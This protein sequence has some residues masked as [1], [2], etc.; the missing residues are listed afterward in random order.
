MKLVLATGEF[1]HC[2]SGPLIYSDYVSNYYDRVI[3]EDMDAEMH[4]P[5]DIT[6]KKI[7]D[8]IINYLI[9]VNKI[10]NPFITQSIFLN[11]NDKDYSVDEI[12]RAHTHGIDVPLK[13]LD[14]PEWAITFIESLSHEDL[15]DVLRYADLLGVRRLVN[16]AAV[17]AARDF[18]RMTNDEKDRVF[19]LE[20][21][22]TLEE[23]AKK[24][25][26]IKSFCVGNLKDHFDESDFK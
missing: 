20:R 15:F 21:T 12:E 25:K 3:P 18:L 14:I 19:K 26:E 2:P 17:R 22:P 7:I 5:M 9:E 11:K 10:P 1:V 16:L 4:L 23:E 13:S 8:Y 24:K 6:S